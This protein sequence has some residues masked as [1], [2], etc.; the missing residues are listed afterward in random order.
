MRKFIQFICYSNSWISAGAASMGILYAVLFDQPMHWSLI[1]FLFF[2][3]SLAYTFQRFEKLRKREGIS[4]ERMDWMQRNPALVKFI[5][6]YSVIG[7]LVSFIFLAPLNWVI[8]PVTAVI[9][10]FYAFKIKGVNLRDIPFIKIVLIGL[11]W[12]IS[13]GLMFFVE[14][15]SL[16]R[17][18]VTY[19][20]FVFCYII[21]ITI[22]FD[23]RDVELD[24]EAKHTLPQMFGV[25]GAKV[26][27]VSLLIVALLL[28]FG[29]VEGFAIAI[30]A[31]GV[32]TGV[33]IVAS[34][35]QKDDLY[36]SFLVDGLL[37]VV[38]LMFYLLKIL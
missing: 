2:S 13:C 3:T 28:L 35:T 7:A 30:M 33:L 37:V 32:I 22:P 4:G 10:F 12:A 36:F 8:V 24:E 25:A 9:S 17:T 27:G 5:L 6:V 20:F 26:I 15:G 31:T 14:D 29:L 16:N 19:S 11:V 18:A 1:A 21:A 38:P 34:D 23:I